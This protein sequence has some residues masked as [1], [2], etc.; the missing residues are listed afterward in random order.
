MGFCNEPLRLVLKQKSKKTFKVS[1]T[2]DPSD[3][4]KRRDIINY[5]VKKTLE[6]NRNKL[7]DLSRQMA[8]RKIDEILEKEQKTSNLVI[9][10]NSYTGLIKSELLNNMKC[11]DLKETILSGVMSLAEGNIYNPVGIAVSSLLP[12]MRCLAERYISKLL[13]SNS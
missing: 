10:D 13:P 11:F 5:D 6:A 8:R 3:I 9:P 2:V 7:Q 1:M 12:T 4:T